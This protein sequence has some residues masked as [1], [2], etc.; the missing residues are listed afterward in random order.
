M[1]EQSEVRATR[2]R[3]VNGNNGS[4][5]EGDDEKFDSSPRDQRGVGDVDFDLGLL[6]DKELVVLTTCRPFF[7]DEEERGDAPGEGCI[8]EFSSVQVVEVG[9]CDQPMPREIHACKPRPWNATREYHAMR[10]VKQ[11]EAK[12][13]PNVTCIGAMTKKTS[14]LLYENRG[15]LEGHQAIVDPPIVLRYIDRL[16]EQATSV[17]A[18][19]SV[20]GVMTDKEQQRGRRFVHM[21][22]LCF[23]VLTA[24][25]ERAPTNS[26]TTNSTPTNTQSGHFTSSPASSS[27]SASSSC[28]TPGTDS[29]NSNFVSP[30]L[31]PQPR[32]ALI[33]TNSYPSFAQHQHQHQQG[34]QQVPP[35][36]FRQSQHHHNSMPPYS[37]SLSSAALAP[38]S[39]S[40]P[41]SPSLSSYSVPTAPSGGTVSLTS[42]SSSLDSWFR[43]LQTPA[44]SPSQHTNDSGL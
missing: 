38:S 5:G 30:P 19:T 6:Q 40:I 18:R 17:S 24:L 23:F 3:K 39:M 13:L 4:E 22:D 31:Q 41:A 32:A 10:K 7:D 1:K 36:G 44:P 35:F 14:E 27:P 42:S 43:A 16:K 26:P 28:A 25:N 33:S 34:H 29:E 37:H 15:V 2:K 12:V 9:E 21:T 11:E 8:L 20:L